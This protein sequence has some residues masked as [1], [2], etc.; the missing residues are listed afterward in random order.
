MALALYKLGAG[1][2]TGRIGLAVL[3]R[4]QAFLRLPA[5]DP[6][7]RYKAVLILAPNRR[8]HAGTGDFYH[9]T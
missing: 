5:S 2:E 7:S 4:A 8:K 1:A 3:G 6:T 9:S